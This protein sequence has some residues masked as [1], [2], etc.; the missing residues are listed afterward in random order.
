MIRQSATLG[1]G[2]RGSVW[3]QQQCQ[4]CAARHLQPP[5]YAT[6]RRSYCVKR[7]TNSL[8]TGGASLGMSGDM[9]PSG[10]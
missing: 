2:G 1:L 10:A 5:R 4:R 7:G 9:E 8:R 6:A 3:R